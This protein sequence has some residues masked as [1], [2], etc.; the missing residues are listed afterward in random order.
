MRIFSPARDL[1]TSSLITGGEKDNHSGGGGDPHPSDRR[2]DGERRGQQQPVPP[3]A[4]HHLPR[5]RQEQVWHIDYRPIGNTGP[6]NIFWGHSCKYKILPIKFYS[7][8]F[9]GDSLMGAL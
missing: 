5:H 8:Q 9:N 2:A 1:T 3:G 6:V 4:A 7:F